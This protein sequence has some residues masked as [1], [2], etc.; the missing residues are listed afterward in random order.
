[1]AKFKKCYKCPDR[2]AD[3][4]CHEKCSYYLEDKEAKEKENAERRK[5]V[6]FLDAKIRAEENTMKK[7]KT[8]QLS[9]RKK[10]ERI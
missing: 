4:N 9:K 6:E 1:M 3:P 10:Y 2:C 5:D 8:G 7:I